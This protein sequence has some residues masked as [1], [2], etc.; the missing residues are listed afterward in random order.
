MATRNNTG[1]D[2]GIAVSLLR[3]SVL[4][5]VGADPR[6]LIAHPILVT[7]TPSRHGFP[8]R[9]NLLPRNTAC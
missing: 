1:G 3:V 4:V 9:A 2:E 5:A 6:R 8:A 7:S